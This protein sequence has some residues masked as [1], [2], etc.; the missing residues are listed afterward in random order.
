[1]DTEKTMWNLWSHCGQFS[2]MRPQEYVEFLI[3]GYI[4]SAEDTSNNLR[5]VFEM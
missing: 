3:H 1:M 4:H 5:I 2:I